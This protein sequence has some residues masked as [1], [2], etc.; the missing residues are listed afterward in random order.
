MDDRGTDDGGRTARERRAALRQA[1]ELWAASQERAP[2][3][4]AEVREHAPL[5]YIAVTRD[6]CPR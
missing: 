3:S 5:W 6:V 1:L 4:L 2:I